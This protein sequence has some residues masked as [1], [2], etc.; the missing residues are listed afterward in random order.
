MNRPDERLK[1]EQMRISAWIQMPP[2]QAWLVRVGDADV[3]GYYVVWSKSHV[4]TKNPQKSA[5]LINK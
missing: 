2:F 4:I 5:R 3:S 1:D